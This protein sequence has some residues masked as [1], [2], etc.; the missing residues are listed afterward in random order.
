M[1]ILS[2]TLVQELFEVIN[3]KLKTYLLGLFL[4][5]IMLKYLPS[6]QMRMPFNGLSGSWRVTKLL[7]PHLTYCTNAA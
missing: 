4:N 7:A 6:P 1:L 5:F 2:F 3:I